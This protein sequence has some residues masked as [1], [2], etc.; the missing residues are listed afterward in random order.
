MT[1][2]II[3]NWFLIVAVIAVFLMI[4]YT[5]YTFFHRPTDD[6]I[7]CIKEWLLYAVTE[8]EKELGSGTGQLK[9]RY[10]YNMFIERFGYLA[11]IITFDMVSDLVDEALDQMK[12]MLSKNDAIKK[13]VDGENNDADTDNKSVI[14]KNK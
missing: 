6:Q 3:D 13:Y 1:K 12:D 9:L 8:A 4:A 7:S 2:N 14:D 11:E 5:A 10:V